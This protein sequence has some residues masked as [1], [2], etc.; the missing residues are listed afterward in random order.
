MSE[1]TKDT[2]AKAQVVLARRLGRPPSEGE[3]YGAVG[4][5]LARVITHIR[6]G[7][8]PQGIEAIIYKSHDSWI[9]RG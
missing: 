8:N 7:G 6:E 9:G 1:I 5:A 2:V 3:L 4:Y